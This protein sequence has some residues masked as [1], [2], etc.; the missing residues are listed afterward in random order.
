MLFVEQ[1]SSL[2]FAQDPSHWS[3]ILSHLNPVCSL[4]PFHCNILFKGILPSTSLSSLKYSHQYSACVSRIFHSCH[5]FFSS[6][7]IWYYQSD[8]VLTG[9]VP[10]MK[11]LQLCYVSKPPLIPPC[12]I[13]IFLAITFFS[14]TV[15]RCSSPGVTD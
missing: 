14:F 13:Q 10:I 3:I 8:Y 11:I 4:L 9:E 7:Y 5:I 15:G 1:E 2:L 12:Y 6:E